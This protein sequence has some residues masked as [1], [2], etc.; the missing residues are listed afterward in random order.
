MAEQV[1]KQTPSKILPG[2]LYTWAAS[3]RSVCEPV[4]VCRS[5]TIV[6]DFLIF[7]E[8][9]WAGGNLLP[10]ASVTSKVELASM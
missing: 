4:A 5:S 2:A 3:C 7:D 8:V 10:L 9:L 1:V 6:H